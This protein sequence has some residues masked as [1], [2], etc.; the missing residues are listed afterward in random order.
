MQ[1]VYQSTIQTRAYV[2]EILIQSGFRLANLH[3]FPRTSHLL[4]LFGKL[5]RQIQS[6]F[7]TTRTSHPQQT[8]LADI[9]KQIHANI[10]TNHMHIQQ[11]GFL[12]LR[13]DVHAKIA[14][15]TLS[16]RIPSSF[17]KFDGRSPAG[18]GGL[19]SLHTFNIVHKS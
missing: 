3:P 1:L 4:S 13:M 14:C 2:A 11:L 19:F 8:K 18:Q 5:N 15:P 10:W 6:V 12:Q 17:S 16:M 7:G 9:H